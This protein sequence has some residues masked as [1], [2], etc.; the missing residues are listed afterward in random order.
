MGKTVSRSR[1]LSHARAEIAMRSAPR[2]EMALLLAVSGLAALLASYGLL[3]WGLFQMVF[4]YPVAAIAGYLVFIL[5]LRVWVRFRHDGLT[6]ED[7]NNA[8]IDVELAADVA[9]DL[10]LAGRGGHD[11]LLGSAADSSDAGWDADDLWFIAILIALVVVLA[12]ALGFV[13]VEAPTLFA[14]VIVDGAF[15]ASLYKKIG[16][17][18]AEGVWIERVVTHTWKSFALIL[19]IT[20]AIGW[21]AQVI[22]PEAATIGEVLH[23]LS[24]D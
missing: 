8:D 13:L 18:A 24:A 17:P 23:V 2:I 21:I 20:A 16:G 9:V 4:R 10:A 15:V 6:W 22:V 12:I 14:E 7:T 3:R 19:V 11:G 5:V 1:L